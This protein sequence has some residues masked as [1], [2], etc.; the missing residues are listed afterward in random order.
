MAT[1]LTITE[2]IKTLG[3]IQEKLGIQLADEPTF[4]NEWL[5][6]PNILSD[7]DRQRLDQI[8]RNY[9][10]QSTEGVL[11]AETISLLWGTPDRVR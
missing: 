3:Q 11:L 8:R 10:Y 4:F 9:L 1:I 6:S 2:A 5:G 7:S